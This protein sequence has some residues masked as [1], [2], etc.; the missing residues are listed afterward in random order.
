MPKRS[1][2]RAAGAK[3]DVKLTPKV[4]AMMALTTLATFGALTTSYQLLFAPTPFA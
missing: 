1:T 2:R 3:D 4:Y